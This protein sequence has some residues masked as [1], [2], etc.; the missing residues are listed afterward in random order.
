MSKAHYVEKKRSKILKP[1]INH[2]KS[3]FNGI[4]ELTMIAEDSTSVIDIW[5]F[6]Q[7]LYNKVSGLQSPRKVT[8]FNYKI[9]LNIYLIES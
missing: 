5:H 6:K 8:I 2:S 4:L 7:R 1:A 9:F 3:L